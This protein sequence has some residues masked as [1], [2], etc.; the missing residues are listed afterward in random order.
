MKTYKTPKGVG[1]RDVT[2]IRAFLRAYKSIQNEIYEID[3]CLRTMSLVEMRNILQKAVAL[4]DA[5][6]NEISDDDTIVE[7]K[8]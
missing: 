7:K 5:N 1:W 3:N 2:P 4:M 8:D 6:L